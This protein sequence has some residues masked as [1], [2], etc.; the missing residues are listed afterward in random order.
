MNK[1]ISVG[2][3]WGRVG[4]LK[5]LDEKTPFFIDGEAYTTF[6]AN[7]ERT[8]KFNAVSPVVIDS[9]YQKDFISKSPTIGT[10]SISFM[11]EPGWGGE[12]ITK[13]VE[14]LLTSEQ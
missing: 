12:S 1:I 3:V 10:L 11:A 9:G 14:F 13:Y 7:E 5:S 8:Y 2:S 4:E 6:L